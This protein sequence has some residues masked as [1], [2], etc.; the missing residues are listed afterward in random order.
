VASKKEQKL[1]KIKQK[2][3]KHVLKQKNW[4]KFNLLCQKN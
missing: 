4:T 1:V 2:I 3:V